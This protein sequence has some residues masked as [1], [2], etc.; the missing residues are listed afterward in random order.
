MS[1]SME[2]LSPKYKQLMKRQA[3]LA[4]ERDK[5]R[6]ALDEFCANKEANRVLELKS[7]VDALISGKAEKAKKAATVLKEQQEAELI[8]KEKLLDLALDQIKQEIIPVRD[9]ARQ[10][11]IKAARKDHAIAASKSM[12]AMRQLAEVQLRELAIIKKLQSSIGPN[13]GLTASWSSSVLLGCE[14]V[15]G[16]PMFNTVKLLRS[17]GYEA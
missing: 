9:E 11:A 17:H 2:S 16:D 7:Q 1:Y 4:E 10:L 6:E 14:D 8:E 5:I 3:E 15:F 12:A 13:S